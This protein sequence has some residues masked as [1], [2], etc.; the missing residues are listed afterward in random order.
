[1]PRLLCN[2]V[3]SDFLI[4]S[5]EG[6]YFLCLV[7]FSQSWIY[8]ATSIA[9]PID[10]HGGDQAGAEES[11]QT[12]SAQSM[13]GLALQGVIEEDVRNIVLGFY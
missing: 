13:Q 12:Q 1:M 5:R 9:Y 8:K 10:H 3:F 7:F 2:N 11:R 4:G 6:Q